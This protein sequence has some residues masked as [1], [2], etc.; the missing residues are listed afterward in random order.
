MHDALHT[1][2]VSINGDNSTGSSAGIVINSQDKFQCTTMHV[3]LHM[4]HEALI[5]V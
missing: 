4:Y 1:L 5:E 2:D 3:K